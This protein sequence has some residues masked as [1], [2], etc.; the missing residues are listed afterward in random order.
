MTCADGANLAA[1][2][3]RWSCMAS[4]LQTGGRGLIRSRAR[5]RPCR[6]DRSTACVDRARRGAASR[7]APNDRSAC[8]QFCRGNLRGI[9]GG[10]CAVLS[11]VVQRHGTSPDNADRADRERASPVPGIRLIRVPEIAS[12]RA[13]RPCPKHIELIG[14]SRQGGNE[15]VLSRRIGGRD[16]EGL[17]QRRRQ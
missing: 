2:S 11:V 3:S 9:C 5:G 16:C 8:S 12:D 17:C 4:A 10:R 1:M 14:A 13:V 15:R 6:T 7:F